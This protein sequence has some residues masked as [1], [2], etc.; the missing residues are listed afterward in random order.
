MA[1]FSKKVHCTECGNEF[2]RS[3]TEVLA[4]GKTVLRLCRATCYEP[5]RKA[6]ERNMF[7]AQEAAESLTKTAAENIKK[8]KER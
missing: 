3:D 8:A 7:Q 5:K 4:F 2:P 6:Q 1:N